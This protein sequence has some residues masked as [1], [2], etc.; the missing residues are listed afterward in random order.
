[1][2]FLEQI[3][4]ITKLHTGVTGVPPPYPG[5]P[6]APLTMFA[7]V[8]RPLLRVALLASA[9]SVCQGSSADELANAN[10]TARQPS[11]G[12]QVYY[13]ASHQQASGRLAPGR[14][15][16]GSQPAA[17]NAAILVHSRELIAHDAK[18]SELAARCVSGAVSSEF[19]RSEPDAWR[20]NAGLS[21][22][23]DSLADTAALADAADFLTAPSSGFLTYGRD[24]RTVE[25]AD[26]STTNTAP[27]DLRDYT[28]WQAGAPK[29][30]AAA[31]QGG[32]GSVRNA[33]VR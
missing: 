9:A 24:L 14:L 32:L 4:T 21:S 15:A 10:R 5:D 6:L 33:A 27:L 30:G 17:A 7:R 2:D 3:L 16:S 19:G 31:Q 13:Q 8:E 29:R 22:R 28:S 11:S 1:M 25:L 18:V 12:S 26:L 20:W 23:A